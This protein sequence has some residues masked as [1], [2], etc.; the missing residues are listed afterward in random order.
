[1]R[2]IVQVEVDLLDVLAVV[3]LAVREPEQPLLQDRVAAVPERQRE[4][5]SLGV[6]ADAGQPVLAPAVGPC[7]RLV[8]GEIVPGVAVL[9]VVVGDGP[10]LPLAQIRP[11]ALPWDGS[12]SLVE[13][14]PL[15]DIHGQ[16]PWF[17]GA[18][19][20]ICGP[21]PAGCAQIYPTPALAAMR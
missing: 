7:D 17:L 10:P 14:P 18:R 13:E 6:V 2:S 4:A 5:E 20:V 19:L 21:G 15:L 1:R 16:Q 9:A 3:P 8:V 12:I 11:P